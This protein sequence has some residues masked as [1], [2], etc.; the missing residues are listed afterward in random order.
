MHEIE[1]I[2]RAC[3]AG[4]VRIGDILEGRVK[5]EL[6]AEPVI[7]IDENAFG[8]QMAVITHRKETHRFITGYFQRELPEH[9]YGQL[10][11]GQFTLRGLQSLESEKAAPAETTMPVATVT[12]LRPRAASRKTDLRDHT[13]RPPVH[14]SGRPTTRPLSSFI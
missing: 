11:A 14:G 7:S 9:V 10:L 4:G 2:I 3:I 13:V 8:R 6:V 1:R 5:V 12:Q